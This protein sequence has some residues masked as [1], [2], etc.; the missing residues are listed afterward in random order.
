MNAQERTEKVLNSHTGPTE[1]SHNQAVRDK[2]EI[3]NCLS[4]H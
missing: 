4:D 3:A 2:G 1:V